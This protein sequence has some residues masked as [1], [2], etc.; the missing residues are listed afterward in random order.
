MRA[1]RAA[2]TMLAV[3]SSPLAS[4]Q[5]MII[6]DSGDSA[7]MLTAS[8]LVL[9]MAIPG[10]GLFYGGLVRSRNLASPLMHGIVTTCLVSLI[11]AGVGYSLSFG[12]GSIWLG[13]LG[14]LGLTNLVD[15][16]DGTTVSEN[17]FVLFQM[18]FAVFTSAL[19]LSAFA[20]HLRLGWVVGFTALWSLLVYVPVTRWIWGGGW[21]A[22]R[23]TLDFAGGIVVQTTAGVAA[24]V[25]ALLLGERKAVTPGVV[26]DRSAVS[27]AG[28]ALLWVGSFGLNGGSS[29]A[30]GADAATAILN[31]HLAASAAALVVLLVEWI[32]V[33]QSSSIGLVTG[34]VAGL[35]T[36]TPAAGF[37]GPVG[38]IVLGSVGGLTAFYALLV[39]E[40]SFKRREFCHVFAVH[41]VAGMLGSLL[42]PLFVLPVFGG[43]G[44]DEGVSLVAQFGAQAVGVGATVLWTAVMTAII[45]LMVA[46]IIPMRAKTRST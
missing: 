9:F 2:M 25:I 37:V 24:L 21:L 12:D 15:I 16:R 7:W 6:A 38:A 29:F 26:E 43:P 44:Y 46:M 27:L 45:A 42:F 33:G 30:A 23:G 4:A 14:N 19:I 34:A 8:A 31:T 41:G 17:L 39:M 22:E 5:P 28:A 13:G 3:T 36:I 20:P 18:T 11:W 10:L 40:K 32:K 35:A 1:L